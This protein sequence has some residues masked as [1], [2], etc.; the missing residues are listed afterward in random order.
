MIK[1]AIYGIKTEVQA[2]TFAIDMLG[3][4]AKCCFFL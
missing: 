2:H 1:R 3:V 4:R